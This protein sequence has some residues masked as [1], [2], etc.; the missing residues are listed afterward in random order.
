MYREE[1]NLIIEI[2]DNGIGRAKA[3]DIKS[4]KMHSRKSVGIALTEERLQNFA[5]DNHISYDLTIED[6]FEHGKPNGTKVVLKFQN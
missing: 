6:A 3:H 1:A 4:K 2:T 5:K